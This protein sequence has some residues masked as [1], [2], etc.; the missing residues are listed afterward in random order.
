MENV[1]RYKLLTAVLFLFEHTKD[2]VG[3]NDL[4]KLKECY[5]KQPNTMLVV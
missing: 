5:I 1:R 3:R 4:K 2:S